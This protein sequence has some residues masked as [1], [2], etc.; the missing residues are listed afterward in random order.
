MGVVC[1][2]SHPGSRSKAAHH[3]FIWNNRYRGGCHGPLLYSSADA[4]REFYWTSGVPSESHIHCSGEAYKLRHNATHPACMPR[5]T[6]PSPLARTLGA[7]FWLLCV[8]GLDSVCRVYMCWC[9]AA[10]T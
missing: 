1:D 6:P 10:T 7:W 4:P 8:D 5:I 3:N 9:M 2:A